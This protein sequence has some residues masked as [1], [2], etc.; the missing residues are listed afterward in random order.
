MTPPKPTGF[1]APPPLP[2]PPTLPPSPPSPPSTP[3]LRKGTSPGP[4]PV[5]GDDGPF[6]RFTKENIGIVPERVCLYTRAGWG[7]TTFAAHCPNVSLIEAPHEM[8]TPVLLKKGS[9]PALD[10]FRP[11]TWPEFMEGLDW[12]ALQEST[13]EERTVALDA[14]DGFERLCHDYETE[15]AYGGKAGEKGFEGYQRGYKTS[16]RQWGLLLHALERLWL[17]GWHVVIT[18]HAHI[19][20]FNDPLG[21]EYD[22]YTMALHPKTTELTLPWF[23]T[24]LF[25]TTYQNIEMGKK[26]KPTPGSG[27]DRVV[28]TEGCDAY[29]AKHRPPMLSSFVVKDDYRE[30]FPTIWENLTNGP[31]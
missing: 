21:V 25:G 27:K 19:V 17:R 12:L 9:I 2:I 11:D 13:E 18:C 15:T 3:P 4:R 26:D 16:L 23:D 30:T 29:D 28:Y 10:V 22:R 20:K 31:R 6:T 14:L 24:I 1:A 7:K 8:G 5:Q